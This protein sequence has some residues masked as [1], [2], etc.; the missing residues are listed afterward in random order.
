[1]KNPAIARRRL[2]EDCGSKVRGYVRDLSDT[3]PVRVPGTGYCKVLVSCDINSLICFWF[4]PSS[5]VCSSSWSEQTW[6]LS[7]STWIFSWIFS[8]LNASCLA[9]AS[10][11]IYG[12]L[13]LCKYMDSKSISKLFLTL[14]LKFHA[15]CFGGEKNHAGW[16]VIARIWDEGRPAT[17]ED[18]GRAI[19]YF[20]T[21]SYRQVCPASQSQL[22]QI[23]ITLNPP[24]VLPPP[25]LYSLYSLLYI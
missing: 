20:G 9:E 25:S 10:E 21:P 11:G 15:K 14:F 13:C 24:H 16:A 19:L 23:S 3:Y 1:M 4:M 5:S 6:A 2:T 17:H 7:F 12:H 22:S 8:F 18:R